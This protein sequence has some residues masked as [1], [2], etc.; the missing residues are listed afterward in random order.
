MDRIEA[1]CRTGELGCVDCKT[2]LADHLI[3]YFRGYR[4][5]RAELETRP[6]VAETVL[7][8]G[9]ERVRPIARATLDAVRAAMHFVP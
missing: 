9:A 4:E 2:L 3:E 7:A 5:R 6:G 8:A 1:T